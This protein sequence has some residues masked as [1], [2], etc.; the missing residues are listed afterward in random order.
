MVTIE[1]SVD[2]CCRYEENSVVLG[3][4]P[5]GLK[6]WIGCCVPMV[7][8]PFVRATKI[9]VSDPTNT[10]PVVSV[11]LRGRNRY[12]NPCVGSTTKKACCECVLQASK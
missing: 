12:E 10:D 3:A 9:R 11:V 2:M 7:K 1:A 5:E 6:E 8:P 4:R